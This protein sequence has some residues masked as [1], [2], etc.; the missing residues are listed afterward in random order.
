MLLT[1]QRP[2]IIETQPSQTSDTIEVLRQIITK[3]E[4]RQIDYDEA[5]EVGDSLIQFFQVLAEAND[6]LEA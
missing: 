5:K 2:G 4:R 6:G 1:S 3:Q